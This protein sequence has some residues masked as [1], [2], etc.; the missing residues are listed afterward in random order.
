MNRRHAVR[1]LF[2]IGGAIWLFP[3]CM[4]GDR[5]NKF[6][7]TKQETLLSE[8]TDALLPATDT[9]GALELGIPLFI[10]KMIEECRPVDYHHSFKEGLD[11]FP[12]YV[13]ARTGKAWSALNETE[14]VALMKQVS[15]DSS[16]T[17]EINTLVNGTR[18]LTIKG[19]NN[20]EYFL[21]KV[22]PYELVPGRFNGCVAISQTNKAI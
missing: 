1:Q 11:Q 18:E 15:K 12:D 19:Y 2:M 6:F 3:A 20:S 5:K 7:T 9:P 13:K 22:V 16:A 10:S 4:E 21:T 17:R 8:M 14:R